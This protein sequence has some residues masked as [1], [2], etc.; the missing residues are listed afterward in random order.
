M[1]ASAEVS[2]LRNHNVAA[3]RNLTQVVDACSPGKAHIVTESQVPRE[4]NLAR[5]V[6]LYIVSDFRP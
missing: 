6:D 5:R 1:R 4:L 3:N 2:V